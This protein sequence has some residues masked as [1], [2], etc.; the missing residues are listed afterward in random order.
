VKRPTQ[1]D[2]VILPP[3]FSLKRR[4]ESGEGMTREEM[5]AAGH[6][7]LEEQR[8]AH[9][10]RLL[11]L[12]E[13][14]ERLSPRAGTDAAALSALGRASEALR[15]EAGTFG[16]EE[17]S[18]I[19]GIVFRVVE[20]GRPEDRRFPAVLETSAAALKLLSAEMRAAGASGLDAEARRLL[21]SRMEEAAQVLMPKR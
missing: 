20:H 4:A 11:G 15:A 1:G 14:I 7:V 8:A 19:A 6:R 5:V 21:I 9:L 16:H 12:V 13:E 17:V 2:V 18:A 3:D 10:P